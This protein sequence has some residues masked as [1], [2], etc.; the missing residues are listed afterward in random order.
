MKDAHIHIE[1]STYTLEWIQQ[2]IQQAMDMGIDEINLLEHTHHFKEWMPLYEDTRNAHPLAKKWIDDHQPIPIQRYYDFIKLA[3]QQEFPI[4]VNFGLE[5]C[6]F[7]S[8]ENFI[9]DMLNEFP[10]DFAIGSI[11]YVYNV[12]YDLKGISIEMLWDQ[13]FVNDIYQEY[14]RLVIQCVES[15]LF[16]QLGHADTIKMFQA[17]QPTIDLIPTYKKLAEA[18]VQH[19]VIAENNVG[20]YYR[21]HHPE[22]GLNDTLLSILQEYH[23]MMTTSSDA[24]IPQHVGMHIKDIYQKTFNN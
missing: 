9:S 10:Y 24:H 8:K 17:Y 1:K 16:T 15:D 19:H 20:C 11:H 13:H 18:L 5:V 2:Y 21:Y 6:Y 22:M 12:P 7:P 3:R 4:K 23:V 14:Y